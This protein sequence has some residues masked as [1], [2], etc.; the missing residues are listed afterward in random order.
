LDKIYNRLRAFIRARPY[1]EGLNVMEE[2]KVSP[3][4]EAAE[5]I[6]GYIAFNKFEPHTKIPSERDLC[7][8]WGFNR[9]TLRS[10]ISRLIEE[11]KLYNRLGSGTFVAPPKVVRNLQ[12]LKS[13]AE[14]SHE[15]GSVLTSKVISMNVLESNKKISQ[16][17]HI[18]LGRKI[19]E[20]LR[21][22]IFDNDPTSIDTSYVEFERFPNLERFDFAKESFYNVLKSEYNV[23]IVGGE[24]K[25]GI[26]YAS[27]VE[28][29]SLSI[30]VETAVF[31][32]NGI[33]WDEKEIPIEYF[34]SIVRSD[35]VRFASVLK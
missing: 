23:K 7:E 19:Y 18:P 8:M 28:A 13:L 9:T 11:G 22:R 6:E 5:N 24:E 32:L 21:I 25:I 1:L 17:L 3:R 33:I 10:A 15:Y 12:D 30:P 16:K 34:K 2:L 35:K 29:K 4:D 31:F 26:T 27:A 14:Y 20:L